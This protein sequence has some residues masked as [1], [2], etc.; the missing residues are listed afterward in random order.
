MTQDKQLNN[1]E[2]RQP[3]RDQLKELAESSEPLNIRLTNDFAFK[4]TFHEKEPLK[5][6][7]SAILLIPPEEIA[8]IEFLDTQLYGE[9][10]EDH[11]G[12]VDIKLYL[13][14]DKKINI[15]M[16]LARFPSWQ[17]RSLFYLCKMYVEGFEKGKGYGKLERCIHISIL[18]FD[19]YDNPPFFST[20]EL[21]DRENNINYSDKLSL[22]VLE[23][24]QIDKV[25]DETKRTDIYKW[26][27][28][29]TATDRE[30][31]EKI[32][33]GDKYMEAAKEEMNKINADK[34]KRYRYL[35][36]EKRE[37][38]AATLKLYYE[39]QEEKREADAATLKL[40]YE[41]MVDESWTEGKTEGKTEGNTEGE[42]RNNQ[43]VKNLIASNRYS[44]LAKST[45]DK[46]FRKKLYKE[47]GL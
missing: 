5:G 41:Q 23:L 1:E 4:T 6:L 18:S 45:E 36:E 2:A 11:E 20:I 16:Q 43:L 42:E 46:E 29:I 39:Q 3:V 47:F 14:G 8:D 32:G 37:A 34:A 28:M 30:A 26:A 25:D 22:R 12:I 40:Y 13:N 24:S 35:Q 19:L 7:L 33:K 17:E 15:E 44:D 10:A 38:D 9:Y 31:L 21:W 27:K